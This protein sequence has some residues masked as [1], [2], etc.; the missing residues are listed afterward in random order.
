M[1][2]NGEA[3]LDE[4]ELSLVE[5]RTLGGAALTG[6]RLPSGNCHHTFFVDL[7]TLY[8]AKN[9]TAD[10]RQAIVDLTQRVIDKAREVNGLT[11]D[12]SGT[13]SQPDDVGYAVAASDMFGTAA[14]AETVKALKQKMDPH[15]RLRFH[16]FA[17]LL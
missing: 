12:F 3:P 11:V 7:I 10:E 6:S 4:A 13:H 16:P 5:I 15:N 1:N 2:E 9:K 17:R 8:D 14:M